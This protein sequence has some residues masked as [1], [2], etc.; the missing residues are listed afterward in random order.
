MLS[1]ACCLPP[2]QVYVEQSDALC[3]LVAVL[4]SLAALTRLDLSADGNFGMNR[5]LRKWVAGRA[6]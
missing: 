2:A 4:G 1:H 5:C 3:A 6:V